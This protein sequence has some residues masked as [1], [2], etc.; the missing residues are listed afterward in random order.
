MGLGY[1]D[2]FIFKVIQSK[3]GV[4]KKCPEIVEAL[5]PP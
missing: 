4:V 1:T 3:K 5:L 2:A